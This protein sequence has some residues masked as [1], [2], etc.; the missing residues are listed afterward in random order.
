MICTKNERYVH[1][2]YISHVGLNA[3]TKKESTVN[4]KLKISLET[5]SIVTLLMLSMGSNPLAAQTSAPLSISD[6]KSSSFQKTVDLVQLMTERAQAMGLT[7]PPTNMHAY[8]DTVWINTTGIQVFYTGMINMTNGGPYFT[9]P[10][11]SFI[12]HFKSQAGKD[13]LIA[14]S[15]LSLLSFN[16]S[17]SNTIFQDSPDRN[18]AIYASFSIGSSI[19]GLTGQPPQDN[20][21]TVDPLTPSADGLSYSWGMTYHDLTAVWWRINPDPLTPTCLYLCLP[22]AITT[23]NKLAFRYNLVL[24]PVAKTAKITGSFVV[25]E[26]TNLW[27]IKWLNIHDSLHYNDTGKYYPNGTQIS[28]QTIHQFATAQRFKLSIVLYQ[29]AV[30][31]GHETRNDDALGNATDAEHNVSS[32]TITTKASDDN[33]KLYDTNF[34][35]KTNYTL[36]NS[37]SG[38]NATYTA[39]T[40]TARI[41]AYAGNNAFHVQTGFVHLEAFVILAFHP[42]IYHN[43]DLDIAKA[44]F[45]YI[46]TYPTWG[47]YTVVHDPTYTAY[48]APE[49]A[50]ALSPILLAA[51][52]IAVI[53][54]LGGAVLYSRRR[55]VNLPVSPAGNM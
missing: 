8:V 36:E 21:A 45:V 42:A 53:A 32:G 1:K 10:M 27:I 4:T 43:D 44:S 6:F 2:K 16:E 19:T 38:Q 20:S 54:V 39:N 41:Y 13:V 5:A 48:Y 14:S 26:M 12:E 50:P 31:I 30:V 46:I 29:T 55:H 3:T 49:Q 22:V 40:R 23:Y 11:Q 17:S 35:T 47:G 18:D 28:T 33:E 52:G 25:G 24:D 37:T 15:F 9:I 51:V 34:G 7:P